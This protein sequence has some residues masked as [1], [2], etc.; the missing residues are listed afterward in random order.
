MNNYTVYKHTAPNGKVYIGITQQEDL[1]RRWQNGN[2]YRS[3]V[4]F[5]RAIQ[6]YG[7][8]NFTHEI[9]YAG[10]TKAEAEALEVQLIAEH[11]ATDPRHGYNVDHGGN[12]SG[13]HSEET[14]RKIS[15]AQRGEKNHNFGKP[16][17]MRGVKA[18]PEQIEVNRRVHLGQPSYWKGKHLKP[19]AIEKLRQPKSEE[20]KRKLSEAKS[21]AVVCVETGIVYK[22]MKSAA[23]ALGI[24]RGS[25]S[26]VCLGKAKTAGGY[27]WQFAEG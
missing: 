20:H 23:E 26:N 13:T 18:T 11:R 27:H 16:S 6:K 21:R 22:S 8:N 9:L 2:G 7:W 5:A 24:N 25:I 3:Q 14:R 1:N 19:E 17:P 12:A 15:E 10:K 4:K